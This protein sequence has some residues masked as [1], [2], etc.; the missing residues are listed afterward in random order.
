MTEVT[1]I[2]PEQAEIKKEP[3][4]EQ[5]QYLA[6][7]FE[8]AGKMS[9]EPHVFRKALKGGTHTYEY[10]YPLMA[11][12][13]DQETANKL[14]AVFGGKSFPV[15]KGSYRWFIK[16]EEAVE[17]ARAI[18]DYAPARTEVIA[19]FIN[20]QNAPTLEEKLQI[21]KDFKGS[22]KYNVPPDRLHIYDQLISNPYFM[23]GVHKART[24]LDIGGRTAESPEYLL[25]QSENQSLLY[26][27]KSGYKGNVY[28]DTKNSS[29][30]AIS[31]T[32]A[33]KLLKLIKDPLP[34]AA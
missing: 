8:A 22:N 11:F 18:K 33:N 26:A 16:G 1:G 27:I 24:S 14:K 29:R 5:L 21:A 30:L 17:L 6:G 12:N 20:W 34:E 7:I 28:P 4:I 32:N 19:A 23:A 9:V 31:Q 15:A 2:V 10:S 13:I 25:I 3:T